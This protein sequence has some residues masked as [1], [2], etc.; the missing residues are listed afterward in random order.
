M[1][2]DLLNPYTFHTIYSIYCSLHTVER[3]I[4]GERNNIIGTESCIP[5]LIIYIERVVVYNSLLPSKYTL[6]S[7]RSWES[8]ISISEGMGYLS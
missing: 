7:T 2:L 3:T 1:T 4:R 6:L 8:Q 5:H